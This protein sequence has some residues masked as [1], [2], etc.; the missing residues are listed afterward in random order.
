MTTTLTEE[1]QEVVKSEANIE[2]RAATR[3]VELEGQLSAERRRVAF[4]EKTLSRVRD[5]WGEPVGHVQGCT[6]A[7][8]GVVAALSPSGG[9]A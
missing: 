2:S 1:L 3:V 6:C 7:L 4:L 5:F 8:C 9:A